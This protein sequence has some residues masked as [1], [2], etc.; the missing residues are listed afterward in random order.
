ML[1]AAA[2]QRAALRANTLWVHTRTI[3]DQT[4]ESL[5]HSHS[6]FKMATR[7]GKA[8]ESAGPFANGGHFVS[9]NDWRSANCTRQLTVGAGQPGN[10]AGNCQRFGGEPPAVGPQPPAFG[11]KAPSDGWQPPSIAR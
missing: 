5:R 11:Q 9:V 7:L 2:L 3:P 1:T 10:R 8:I 4:A 6:L